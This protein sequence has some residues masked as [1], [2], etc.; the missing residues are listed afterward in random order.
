M[1][2]WQYLKS[3][4]YGSRL[5]NFGRIDDNLFR[6]G[7]PSTR[8]YEKLSQFGVRRVINLIEGEQREEFEKARGRGL[9]W[10]HIPL[11]DRRPP[12]A[13]DVDEYVEALRALP[14]ST[15]VHCKGGRHRTGVMVGVYRALFYGWGIEQIHDE[16]KRHGWYGSLGHQPLLDWLRDFVARDNNRVAR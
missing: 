3:A 1:W 7:L 10:I 15:Y 4:G 2:I 8:G 6:G 11:S 9:D 14:V 12:T 5:P 16:M 13:A